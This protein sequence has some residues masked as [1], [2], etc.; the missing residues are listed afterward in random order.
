M[1]SILTSKKQIW[2]P[3]RH[4]LN[5]QFQHFVV[6]EQQ[7]SS[8]EHHQWACQETQTAILGY[9]NKLQLRMDRSAQRLTPSRTSGRCT[10]YNPSAGTA[11]PWYAHYIITASH[12]YLHEIYCCSRHMCLLSARIVS[13]AGHHLSVSAARGPMQRSRPSIIRGT[14]C[15]PPP[16]QRAHC[17]CVS[18][19]ARLH[20]SAARSPNAKFRRQRKKRQE[21]QQ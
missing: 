3:R 16:K 8:S 4:E 7:Y 5:K 1:A 19:H 15:R 14:N 6:T 17:F 21:Q 12:R 9:N 10:Y 11:F 13:D 20:D 18:V 2:P